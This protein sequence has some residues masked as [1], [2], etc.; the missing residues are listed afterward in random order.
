MTDDDDLVISN[1]CVGTT[2]TLLLI[3]NR[4]RMQPPFSDIELRVKTVR[5]CVTLRSLSKV[6][7]LSN[8][9]VWHAF[10]TVS[11]GNNPHH[12]TESLR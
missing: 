2:E 6:V 7:P 1:E 9:V 5:V 4:I 10:T 3:R 8:P 12:L 11:I